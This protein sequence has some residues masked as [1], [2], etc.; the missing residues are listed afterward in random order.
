MVVCQDIDLDPTPLVG[1]EAF[2]QGCQTGPR[3][4]RG[5]LVLVGQPPDQ[6]SIGAHD[7]EPGLLQEGHERRAVQAG[8]VTEP[9]RVGPCADDRLRPH[10]R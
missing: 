4:H 3:S 2:G 10:L 6:R 7:G 5:E 1:P 9:H 8:G